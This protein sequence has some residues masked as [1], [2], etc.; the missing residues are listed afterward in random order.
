[1][2][3][4]FILSCAAI[5]ITS[6]ALLANAQEQ[7]WGKCKDQAKRETCRHV[8]MVKMKAER[9]TKWHDELKITPAQETAWKAFL[10]TFPEPG[11][12]Q[13]PSRDEMEKMSAPERLE[14]HIAMM[15]KRHAALKTQLA[16][17]KNLYG[18]LTPEQQ[19]LLN[20]RM[21]QFE[22]KRHHRHH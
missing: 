19:T 16:A 2:N 1:M 18:K 4:R 14:K 3:K 9:E 7:D 12:M 13:K 22:H 6:F 17:L 5:G 21:A 15:E 8:Q 11:A 10:E 20:K